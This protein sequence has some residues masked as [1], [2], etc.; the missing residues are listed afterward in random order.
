MVL[1]LMVMVMMMIVT[2][3]M[4]PINAVGMNYEAAIILYKQC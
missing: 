2:M 3:V 1:S 4:T